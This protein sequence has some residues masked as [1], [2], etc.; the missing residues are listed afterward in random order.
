MRIRLVVFHVQRLGWQNSLAY[1]RCTLSLA[2]GGP[3]YSSHRPRSFG[4][5]PRSI[6]VSKQ[7]QVVGQRN[8]LI[9]TIK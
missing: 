6:H 9:S 4:A 3:P 7:Q 2:G 5:F 8:G 1:P